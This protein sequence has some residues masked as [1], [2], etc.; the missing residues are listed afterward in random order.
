M[1]P[2][3]G[4]PTGRIRET[5]TAPCER[6][7]CPC[8]GTAVLQLNDVLRRRALLALHDVELDLIALGQGL[9]SLR[10]NGGVMNEAVLLAALRR[11]KTE[12]LRVVEPLHGTGGACHLMELLTRD[13]SVFPETQRGPQAMPRSSRLTGVRCGTMP[14]VFARGELSLACR[15]KSTGTAGPALTWAPSVK[16]LTSTP[17]RSLHQRNPAWL[18]FPS[19]HPP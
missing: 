10:L 8:G 14:Q 6:A 4:T 11:D 13:L 18:C 19:P 15:R 17:A 5:N 16:I 3:C 1:R 7:P 9:E 12:P 2:P